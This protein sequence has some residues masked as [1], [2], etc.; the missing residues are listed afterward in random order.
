[1]SEEPVCPFQSEE[2]F[3]SLRAT[4]IQQSYGESR[5]D[6]EKKVISKFARLKAAIQY[7][8]ITLWFEHDL[9]C[10]VNLLFLL[11]WLADQDL[12]GT[13]ISLVSTDHYPSVENFK[14]M[15][16][17]TPAQL[18]TLFRQRIFLDRQD[19]HLGRTC[20]T[21]YA[22]GN[23]THL[24]SLLS[25][26]FGQLI[27][28]RNAL[29]AHLERFPSLENGLNRTEQTMLTL[30]T[31]NPLDQQEWVGEVLAQDFIYGFG[32]WQVIEYARWLSPAL[33]ALHGQVSITELGKQVLAGNQDLIRLGDYD[34]WL[35]GANLTVQSPGYRWNGRVGRLEAA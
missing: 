22:S 32:D 9:F 8:E 14:G 20:W 2:A 25:G 29:V 24:E 31:A 21:A 3:W 19:L 26:N 17:L 28:L 12:P 11:S 27:Y 30:L 4:F 5:E 7:D 18:A 23:P 35:G 34:R 13:Q 33:L 10:Q 6:Y 16:Q 15:G 1:M